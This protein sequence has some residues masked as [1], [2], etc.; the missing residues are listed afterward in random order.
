VRLGFGAEGLGEEE[1]A[2]V[3]E[4]ALDASL[5]ADG[6]ADLFGVVLR[7]ERGEDLVGGLGVVRGFEET[8]D[9]FFGVSGDGDLAEGLAGR[10]STGVDEDEDV[11]VAGV[12]AR[13]GDVLGEG[14]VVELFVDDDPHVDVVAAHHVEQ[15]GV[16]FD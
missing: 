2:I 1:I 13:R 10:W 15:R 7:I 12:G 3:G 8:L 5:A 14:V 9:A 4:G 6:E 11:A 16:A